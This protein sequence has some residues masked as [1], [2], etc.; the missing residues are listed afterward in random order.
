M[1][2]KKCNSPSSTDRIQSLP[3]GTSHIDIEAKIDYEQALSLL[4]KCS[5]AKTVD[6]AL[7][8]ITNDACALVGGRG[9]SIWL[10]S[11]ED[12]T[13]VVLRWTYR[14]EGP[15]KVG[16]SYYTNKLDAEGYH[17]GLTGWV[18][19]TGKPLCLHD[20]T[21][22]TEISNYPRLKWVDKYKGFDQA[23]DKKTQSHFM[24]VPIFS[25]RST[26]NVI[27]VLRLG[28]T[29]TDKPFDDL[30]LQLLQTCS[31]YISGLLTNLVK[32]EEE[33]ILLD[34]FFTIASQSDLE[35]LLD[36]AARTIPF[37]MDGSH[38]SIFLK[39]DTGDFCLEAT[40]APHLQKYTRRSA[41]ELCLKYKP[42]SGKTGTVGLTGKTYR[43]SGNILSSAGISHELCECGASSGA[44]LCSPVGE[45]GTPPDGVVRVVRDLTVGQ[46][47][48]IDDERFLDSFGLKL[49]KSLSIHGYFTKGTCFVIMPFGKGLDDIYRNIIKPTVQ[50][51]GFVCRRED[52]FPSIGV[53]PTGVVSH[54]ANASF[55]IADLTGSNP[56]VYYEL[57]IAH[58]LDKLVILISQEASP[59]DIKHWKYIN[60]IDKLGYACILQESIRKAIDEALE[61]S[62]IIGIRSR[63]IDDLKRRT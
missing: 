56:N 22:K 54:I 2:K 48:D 4:R 49:H 32:R 53:L 9:G 37:V 59:T 18:F 27:G 24:A 28:A 10:V 44:F 35:T 16:H 17:D 39:D 19:A 31:G 7:R 42:G 30:Q 11:S 3:I 46:E 52:E 15:N 14:P 51:F 26:R 41:K 36:E 29:S 58:T 34:R 62:R 23:Q 57:G 45:P 38:S 60:Y 20:I 5:E 61:T 6:D 13:K 50:E 25:C 40:S 33:R 47:F 43:I 12:P 63:S 1:K 55:I 8:I 21:D